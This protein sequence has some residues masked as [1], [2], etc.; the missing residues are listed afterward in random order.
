MLG[1]FPAQG[2]RAMGVPSAVAEEEAPGPSIPSHWS[3]DTLLAAG[4]QTHSQYSCWHSMS[5][6]GPRTVA[7]DTPGHLPQWGRF[8]CGDVGKLSAQ[9]SAMRVWDDA[10]T[11]RPY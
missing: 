7:E 4:V 2:Q 6:L 5:S 3:D 8:Q 11:A 1:D 9:G 10:N